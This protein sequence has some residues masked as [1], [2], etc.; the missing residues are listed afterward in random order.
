MSALEIWL[1]DI[2]DATWEGANAHD[3]ALAFLPVA[4]AAV[5]EA[6]RRRV[7]DQELFDGVARALSA[8]LFQSIEVPGTV[9]VSWEWPFDEDGG[10]D[11]IAWFLDTTASLLVT[12]DVFTASLDLAEVVRYVRWRRQGWDDSGWPDEAEVPPRQLEAWA[13]TCRDNLLRYPDPQEMMIAFAR[14]SDEARTLQMHSVGS[15]SAR[16]EPGNAFRL[17]LR[18]DPK[19]HKVWRFY[20]DTVTALEVWHLPEE[21]IDPSDFLDEAATS[22]ADDKDA[23]AAQSL[24]VVI[25]A[26][27]ELQPAGWEFI[28]AGLRSPLPYLR[29]KGAQ[30]LGCWQRSGW[31]E[32]AGEAL[33]EAIDSETHP[34]VIRHLRHAVDG[35]VD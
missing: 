9:A 27:E 31:P 6:S 20:A 8:A 4:M 17:L 22:W 13:E 34:Y 12:D 16:T 15:L 30:T 21:L 28:R 25:E 32:D 24:A 5:A 18:D 3:E 11:H 14:K 29:V 33:R 10:A 7:I 1:R 19:R 23:R 2:R 35:A 26:L